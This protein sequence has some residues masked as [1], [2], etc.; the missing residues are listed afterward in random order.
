MLALFLSTE[1]KVKKTFSFL[2]SARPTLFGRTFNMWETTWGR[3]SSGS[4][5]A[6]VCQVGKNSGKRL[7]SSN[8]EDFST[9]C[10]S[11]TNE[12]HR[13]YGSTRWRRHVHERVPCKMPDKSSLKPLW[14]DSISKMVPER[15][16]EISTKPQLKSSMVLC[17]KHS[18]SP[19]WGKRS[20]GPA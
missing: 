11:P 16:L 9:S 5:F 14:A 15:G 7:K 4:K 20:G 3:N 17:L 1:T 19:G 8:D 6:S 12:I 18:F 2:S 10:R 13:V